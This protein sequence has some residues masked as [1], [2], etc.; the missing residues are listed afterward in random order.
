MVTSK[1]Q[2]EAAQ[3][4]ELEFHDGRM[5]PKAAPKKAKASDPKPT[6]GSLF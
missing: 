3:V 1:D 4:L 2:A 6:Q 5:T